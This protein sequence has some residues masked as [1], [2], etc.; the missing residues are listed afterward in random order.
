[1][2]KQQN[3]KQK[4][5]FLLGAGLLHTERSAGSKNRRGIRPRLMKMGADSPNWKPKGR[6]NPQPTTNMKSVG[7]N[8]Y[9]DASGENFYAHRG[10]AQNLVKVES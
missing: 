4:I 9:V 5:A 8:L 2:R 10:I 6:Q 3:V 7:P 1:M